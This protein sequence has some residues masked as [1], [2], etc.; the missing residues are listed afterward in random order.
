MIGRPHI[1]VMIDVQPVRMVE[2]PGT[3]AHDQISQPIKFGDR[4]E[5]GAETQV[6][7]TM[8]ETIKTWRH[9]TGPN[10]DAT[11]KANYRAP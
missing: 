6:R 8:T 9:C 4:V 7:M 3:E 2:H 5:L 11:T 1:A 10:M